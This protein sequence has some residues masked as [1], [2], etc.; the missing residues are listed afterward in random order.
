MYTVILPENKDGFIS[1]FLICMTFSVILLQ[2]LG[3]LVQSWIESVRVDILDLFLILE[4]KMLTILSSMVEYDIS[5][6]LF[7]NTL[8]QFKEVSFCFWL[9]ESFQGQVLSAFSA[10]VEL[11]IWFSPY[12][13]DIVIFSDWFSNNKPTLHSCYMHFLILYLIL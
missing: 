1:S 11:T 4:R 9:I 8:Y 10:S 2:T 13:I 6:K 3:F 5:Y 12:S 7:I